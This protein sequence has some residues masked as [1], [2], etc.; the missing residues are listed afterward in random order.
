MEQIRTGSVLPRM[1]VLL[2][3]VGV[4]FYAIGCSGAGDL[5]KVLSGSGA[6]LSGTKSTLDVPAGSFAED[7]NVT[8]SENQADTKDIGDVVL[9]S[10]PVTLSFSKVRPVQT[11]DSMSLTIQLDPDP[12][13]QA[14]ADGKGIYAKMRVVGEQL[15]ADRNPSIPDRWVPVLGDLDPTNA[16]L[17]INLHSGAENVEVVAVAG[18][19]LKILAL[20]L[21]ENKRV[22]AKV[23]AGIGRNPW[24]VVCDTDTLANHGAQTCDF[25]NPQSV[26]VRLRER[27]L[28]ASIDLARLG[29]DRM[30]I[31]QMTAGGLANSN[32]PV[33]PT[34]DVLRSQNQNVVYNV[35]FLSNSDQCTVEKNR[36]CYL[37]TSGQIMF[38][39]ANMDPAY[40]QGAGDVVHHEMMHAVQAGMCPSCYET[41][42]DKNRNSPV[43]EGTATAVGQWA[44]AGE[45]A[46]R[47]AGRPLFGNYR[48]WT[49]PLGYFEDYDK[50]YEMAEFFTLANYGDLRYLPVFLRGFESNHEGVFHRRLDAAI[51]AA[52]GEY[53]PK[54]FLTRVMPTRSSSPGFLDEYFKKDITNL[55]FPVTH[56]MQLTSMS[57]HGYQ[58]TVNGPGQT[59]INVFLPA[60]Y[61]SPDIALLVVGGADGGETFAFGDE[62]MATYTTTGETLTVAGNV[63]DVQ[64]LNMS[65]GGT[66]DTR[67]YKLGVYTDGL[68]QPPV[69]V[70]CN[71]KRIH[72]DEFGC[73]LWIQEIGERC[74]AKAL[75]C[76]AGNCVERGGGD[77]FPMANCPHMEDTM[78]NVAQA[79][80]AREAAARQNG[81]PA[82]RPGSQSVDM[83]RDYNCDG[84]N[85]C[86]YLVLCAR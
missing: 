31:N 12:M 62:G 51:Y 63:A 25:S 71:N 37:L 76:G 32:I 1:A 45:D 66:S 7:V 86:Q 77:P 59:C 60:E 21:P 30:D 6:S 55:D 34:A 4:W 72:C 56:E 47:L 15:S 78:N 84:H 26:A 75:D 11:E 43:V 53:L 44:I 64:V 39:E 42:N 82:P 81:Q 24:A 57:A 10:V 61:V 38:A 35:A 9:L 69:P 22:K 16:R 50:T 83:G 54:V 20:D 8:L 19:G 65:T 29:F 70:R 17:T 23:R 33:T 41:D 80:R 5:A 36:S 3:A 52:L 46:G 73:S 58:L 48:S 79:N 74:W 28:D 67:P 2:V 14:I 40:N 49:L 68:C 18:T 85:Y 27:L 13:R